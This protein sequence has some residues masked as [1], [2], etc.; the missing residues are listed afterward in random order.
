MKDATKELNEMVKDCA[1][2]LD[3]LGKFRFKPLDDLDDDLGIIVLETSRDGKHWLDGGYSITV[4]DDHVTQYHV[5]RSVVIPGCYRTK[6]GDG[7][8]DDVDIV[9]VET[10]SR[11]DEAFVR[12]LVEWIKE[13]IEIGLQNAA[14]ARMFAE[15]VE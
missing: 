5:E 12:V 2:Q 7:W 15:E 1:L 11:L 4:E 8:P 3:R 9:P 10:Y 6:N 13:G 14:E